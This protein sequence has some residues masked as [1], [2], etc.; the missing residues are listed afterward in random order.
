M[1]F[2]CPRNMTEQVR[3]KKEGR[4]RK[5]KRKRKQKEHRKEYR[6]KHQKKKMGGKEQKRKQWD[7]RGK[8]KRK[9]KKERNLEKDNS[10]ILP[11]R[12]FSKRLISHI[13]RQYCKSEEE[14]YEMEWA[15]THIRTTKEKGRQFFT[16]LIPYFILKD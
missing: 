2:S 16:A 9:K 14:G 6:K 1:Y 10:S 11:E 3:K 7:K 4:K 13:L 12:I 15:A 5:E 8:K